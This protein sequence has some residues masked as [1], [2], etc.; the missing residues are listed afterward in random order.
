V[1]FGPLTDM[2]VAPVEID[3]APT[4]RLRGAQATQCAHDQ[5]GAK[6]PACGADQLLDV[7]L[8]GHRDLVLDAARPQHADALGGVNV[9]RPRPA[10]G[11]ARCP[12]G[13]PLSERPHRRVRGQARYLRDR[14]RDGPSDR[15]LG[16]AHCRG[17]GSRLG[18]PHRIEQGSVTA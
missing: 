11:M 14:R 2:D 3:V 13:R 15:R 7:L 9:E 17:H 1:E 4:A 12:D 10:D 18:R 5:Q 6:P 8:R 16:A